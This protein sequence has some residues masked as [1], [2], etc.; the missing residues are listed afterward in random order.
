MGTVKSIFLIS[1]ENLFDPFCLWIRA[2]WFC[3]DATQVS[4]LCMEPTIYGVS[5]LMNLF[6]WE[7]EVLWGQWIFSCGRKY[8]FEPFKANIVDFQEWLKMEIFTA[9]LL[10]LWV[11]D[12]TIQNTPP[13]PKKKKSRRWFLIY[14][15]CTQYI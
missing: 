10:C 4:Q 9:C 12:S 15:Y 14:R 2:E 1:K 11:N 7:R 6:C 3:S 5:I 13:P 8:F